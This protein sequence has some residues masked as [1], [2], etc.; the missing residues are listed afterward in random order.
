MVS[1]QQ[2]QVL[3]PLVTKFRSLFSWGDG[4]VRCRN[5]ERDRKVGG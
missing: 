4:K 3:D 1:Q 2:G 5:W